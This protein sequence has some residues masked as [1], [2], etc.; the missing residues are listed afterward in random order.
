MSLFFVLPVSAMANSHEVHHVAPRAVRHAAPVHQVQQTCPASL[1][2]AEQIACLQTENAVLKTKIEHRD[3][4]Q[5]FDNPDGKV[6]DRKIA[7]LPMVMSTFAV[8][9]KSQAVLS[10]AGQDGGTLIVSTGQDLPQGWKV[11]EIDQGRVVI[12]RGKER[13][14]LFLAGGVPAVNAQTR[15]DGLNPVFNPAPQTPNHQLTQ[16]PPFP[17]GQTNPA[18]PR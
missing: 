12:Q 2:P 14:M 9:G 17:V 10:W 3:L 11:E 6:I 15:V 7:S 4:V 5:K 1:G 18:Q 13:H 16:V 8:N